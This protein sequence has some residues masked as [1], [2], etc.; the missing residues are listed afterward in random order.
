MIA[1]HDNWPS[2]NIVRGAYCPELDCQRRALGIPERNSNAQ[3][4]SISVV[5][6]P[7]VHSV[8]VVKASAK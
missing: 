3:L 8:F 4:R 5:S 6:V 2:A 1:T 7:I